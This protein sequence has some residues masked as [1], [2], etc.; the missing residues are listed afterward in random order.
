MKKSVWRKIVLILSLVVM[1]ILVIVVN[2]QHKTMLINDIKVNIDLNGTDTLIVAKEIDNLIYKSFG[3]LTGEIANEINLSQIEDSIY[4]NPFIAKVDSYTDLRGNLHIN[5]KQRKPK[6]R[7]SD[8]N[9]N[10][11]YI[12]TEGYK[13]PLSTK[14]SPNVIIANGYIKIDKKAQNPV[15]TV[16]KEYK[17]ILKSSTDLEKI[18]FLANYIESHPFLK[19]QIDQIYLNNKKE[20]ELVPKIG[21][22]IIVFGNLTR[23]QEKFEN[24]FYLYTDGFSNTGWN[25]YKT[26]NLKFENQVVCTK[27]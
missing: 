8:Q 20:F 10:Q 7:I 16:D 22:Q 11:F 21:N 15:V 6:I 4:R 14:G 18:Y 17:D 19:N 26:I 13:I 2:R 9:G 1:I 5:I 27:Y 12:D 25:I 3:D 24:L 23:I